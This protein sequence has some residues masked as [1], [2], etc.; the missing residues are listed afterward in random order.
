M[1]WTLPR[2]ILGIAK[3]EWGKG[4][5]IFTAEQTQMD[6]GGG[7]KT[8]SIARRDSRHRV[9]QLASTKQV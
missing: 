4:Q 1:C 2:G 7:E 8:R 9:Q 3:R 5:K 6:A